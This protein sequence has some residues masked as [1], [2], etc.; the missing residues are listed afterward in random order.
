MTN[1]NDNVRISDNIGVVA[2]SSSNNIVI[3]LLY[4]EYTI[5]I[6]LRGRP[7]V[8]SE[9]RKRRVSLEVS[10]QFASFFKKKKIV[11]LYH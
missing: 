2:S 10:L 3:T 11:D 8:H 9:L 1:V 4:T 5:V 6:L 7:G